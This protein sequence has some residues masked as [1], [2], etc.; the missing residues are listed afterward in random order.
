MQTAQ[1]WLKIERIGSSK[2]PKAVVWL[3]PPPARPLSRQIFY[4]SLFPS[5]YEF[6]AAGRPNLVAKGAA[7]VLL[8]SDYVRLAFDAGHFPKHIFRFEFEGFSHACSE[9]SPD[10]SHIQQLGPAA[11]ILLVVGAGYLF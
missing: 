6:C 5:A 1:G 3:V 9:L 8:K 11:E 10:V 2:R 4:T 7:S